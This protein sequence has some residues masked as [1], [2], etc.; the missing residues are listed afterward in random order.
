VKHVFEDLKNYFAGIKQI[1]FVFLTSIDIQI[2]G[3]IL[4]PLKTLKGLSVVSIWHTAAQGGAWRTP[5]RKHSLAFA[6]ALAYIPK[7]RASP[8]AKSILNSLSLQTPRLFPVVWQLRSLPNLCQ[9]HIYVL[10]LNSAFSS[11]SIFSF[12]S[13]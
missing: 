2:K 6:T 9:T 4:F 10:R 12:F 1:W 7:P 13:S 3:L 5:H 11:L 8:V